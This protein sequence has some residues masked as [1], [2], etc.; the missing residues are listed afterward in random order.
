MTCRL[1]ERK[2]TQSASDRTIEGQDVTDLVYLQVLQKALVRL[3]RWFKR[4]N[5]SW[6]CLAAQSLGKKQ[7]KDSNIGSDFDHGTVPHHSSLKECK[8]FLLVIQAPAH[9]SLHVEFLKV[10]AQQHLSMVAQCHRAGSKRDI[11]PSDRVD[12]VPQ[13]LLHCRPQPARNVRY[14][15]KIHLRGDLRPCH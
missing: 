13:A 14:Y 5:V 11:G 9:G 4:K 12:A 3:A 15:G 8:D 7:C 1:K 6:P 10:W 2:E